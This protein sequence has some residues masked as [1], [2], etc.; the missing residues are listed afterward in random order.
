MVNNLHLGCFLN[1][2]GAGRYRVG[3]AK[4]IKHKFDWLYCKVF[5]YGRILKMLAFSKGI[6]YNIL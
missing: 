3:D 6:G 4:G 2:P 5:R 1:G